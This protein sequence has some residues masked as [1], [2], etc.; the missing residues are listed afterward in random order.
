MEFNQSPWLKEYIDF[1]T[2]KRIK[3][4][5]SFEK[6]FFKDMNNPVFGKTMENI[7]KRF[8]VNLIIDE[9]KLADKPTYIN[10]KISN[11]N[12]VAVHKI[13]QTLSLNRP[14][15]MGVCVLDLSTTPMYD[16]HYYYSLNLL[17]LF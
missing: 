15:Y 13:K 7:R 8:D 4:K 10:C 16:F 6:N 11:E 14:A 9:Q 3:A 17:S 2:K 1:N 5:N 12:F